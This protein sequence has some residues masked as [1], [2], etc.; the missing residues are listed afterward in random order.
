MPVREVRAAGCDALML[1][2]EV[3]Q[4]ARRADPQVGVWEAADLQWWSRRPRS[5]DRVAQLFWVD[6]GVPVAAAL[7][8][9]WGDADWQCDPIVVPGMSSPAPE[10]VWA[11]ALEEAAAQAVGKV[12]VPVSDDDPVFAELAAGSGLVAGERDATAWMDAGARPG[13]QRLADGYSLVDRTQRS[14]TPHPM[15]HR[16]G[17]A[18]EER[19][20]RCSLYDP[21]L[22][23]A[24]ETADGSVAGYSLYWFDP[25]TG[26]GLVEPV[27]V[28][29]EHQRRGLGRAM[30]AAGIERLAERGARRVKIS[31]ETEAA[32]ALY[33]G[34]GFEPTSTTTWYE[35]R[36]EHLRRSSGA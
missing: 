14:G 36:V 5:S 13:P 4:R 33:R 28:E 31:Y 8:T 29:D 35:G 9:S 20:G 11:R 15:R 22:D 2:V 32:G 19:L 12:A 26:V 10:V 27:R 24:V 30:L 21:A 1:A 18:V 34:V 17:D 23:L 3:L 6:G 25:T 16:N 7:L